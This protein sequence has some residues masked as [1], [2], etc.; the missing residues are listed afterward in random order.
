MDP[1]RY[2]SGQSAFRPTS[3][4][5]HGYSNNFNSLSPTPA[6]VYP[7]SNSNN[8]YN[9]QQM[10]QEQPRHTVQAPRL[11][12]SGVWQD[13]MSLKRAEIINP[14]PLNSFPPVTVPGREN[15]ASTMI[16]CQPIMVDDRLNSNGL[17]P[18]MQQN[19]NTNAHKLM[20]VNYANDRMPQNLDYSTN[21]HVPL[22][23]DHLRRLPSMSTV[24]ARNNTNH[25]LDPQPVP[26]PTFPTMSNN[27][28]LYIQNIPFQTTTFQPQQ[29]K[30]QPNKNQYIAN[31]VLSSHVAPS[32][33]H[34][35]L[36]SNASKRQLPIV[37]PLG[38]QP[39]A[40]QQ[41]RLPQMQDI[42]NKSP[43]RRPRMIDNNHKPNDIMRVNPTAVATQ[44]INID[45]GPKL[46]NSNLGWNQQDNLIRQKGLKPTVHAEQRC[47]WTVV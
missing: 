34:D 7:Y 36:H 24:V 19:L 47:S 45:R 23:Q 5:H 41:R 18:M 29:P 17:S 43:S 25:I 40:Q 13:D 44:T 35:S 8:N 1:S 46:V 27:Q 39:I 26:E 2:S 38:P 15:G 37:T 6:Q 11:A 21:G 31:Q 16:G 4:G 30:V 32:I 42:V 20:S 33:S 22:H 10:I 28:P 3:S 9:G 14:N 12:T